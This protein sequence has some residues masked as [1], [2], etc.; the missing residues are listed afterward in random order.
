MKIHKLTNNLLLNHANIFRRDSE[1][2]RRSEK[3]SYCICLLKMSFLKKKI[4]IQTYNFNTYQDQGMV[5]KH[6]SF[7]FEL[8]KLKYNV[9]PG[10]FLHVHFRKLLRYHLKKALITLKYQ[11]H[12]FT[13][14]KSLKTSSK[15]QHSKYIFHIFRLHNGTISVRTLNKPHISPHLHLSKSWHS[16]QNGVSN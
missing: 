11:I 14:R 9:F 2:L 13:L 8:S 1:I 4:C 6:I 3:F 12:N 7:P 15:F 10:Y 5:H 16:G